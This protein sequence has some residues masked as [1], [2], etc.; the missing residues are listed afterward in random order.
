MILYIK[1]KRYSFFSSMINVKS[2]NYVSEHLI[3]VKSNV[4]VWEWKTFGLKPSGYIYFHFVYLKEIK[5]LEFRKTF[6][7][8]TLIPT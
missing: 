3:T 4:P 5:V 2:F 1:N 6:N 7:S 8:G